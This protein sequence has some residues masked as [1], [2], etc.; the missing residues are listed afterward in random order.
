[1]NATKSGL[2]PPDMKHLYG[3]TLQLQLQK[4]LISKDKK[5]FYN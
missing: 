1:M 4:Y 5:N 3:Q 2:H